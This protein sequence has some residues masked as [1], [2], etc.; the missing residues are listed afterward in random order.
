MS[1]PKRKSVSKQKPVSPLL[2]G[3][4]W[5]GCFTLTAAI[6][7]FLGISVALKSP[8][9]LAKKLDEPI[10][11]LV[12]GIDR[13]PN[14]DQADNKSVKFQGRSD[15]MLLVRVNPNN[16]TVKI[17]SIPRDTRARFPNDRY[18]K[19]NSAN[20]RGGVDYTKEVISDNL[21]DITVDKHVRI[22]SDAFRGLID[23][24]GG[25]EVDV[26]KDMKY[27]DKTQGLYIDLKKGDALNLPLDDN[28]VD[29]AG[30]NCLFNIFKE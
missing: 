10:N 28:S 30:Q 15:T 27:T 26:P 17:L 25:V 20:A 13:V 5:G 9:P 3:F 12:M 22:T 19:I 1:K 6:S 2:Q 16:D 23:A 21:T 29:V 14:A 24:V 18:Y 7:G 4:I 8:L 11:I